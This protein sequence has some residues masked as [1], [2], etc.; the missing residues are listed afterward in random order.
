[1]ALKD[2]LPVSYLLFTYHGRIGRGTYW[3]ASLFIWTSFY[4]LFNLLGLISYSATWVIYPLLF[5]AIIATATKRLHDTNK[6]GFWLWLVLIPV[7]GPILLIYFLGFR[8]GKKAPN[9]FGDFPS[10]APDYFKNN[11]GIAIEHLKSN[12]R[13]INDVTQLNPV[14][15]SSIAVPTS[16]ETLQDIIKKSEKVSIGGGRFSMGG[17]TASPGTAHIDMRKLNKVLVFSKEEKTIKVEAGIRWCD[18]QKYID[19][20]DLSIKIMQTYAN[21]TVGGALSVNCHGRYIGEGA[22]ILSVKNIEV[23]MATGELEFCSPTENPDLFFACIGC[24]NAV[25]VIATVTFDLADNIPVKRVF[26]KLDRSEYKDFFDKKVSRNKD[27]IFHNGNIYPPHYKRVRAVSWVKTDEKP[28]EK[29]RLMPLAGAYPLERYFINAFSKNKFGKW[30]REHIIDPLV[31]RSKKIHW[32]NY[33]AGYD[34]LELEPE[35]RKD[36]TYVLQEYFVPVNNFDGFSTLMAEI[37]QRHNVN[38]INISI[39]HAE[40]DK[41]SLLAWSREEVFAFVVWHKQFTSDVEKG[42]VAVWTRE[43]IDAAIS[44]NGSYYLPY[45]AHATERQFHKAYP[46]AKKL[47][48]LKSE[49]DPAFKFRNVLWDTYYKT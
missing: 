15:V 44:Q 19:Q 1:M 30:R 40:K 32:R 29:T 47:F 23:I 13:I 5:W 33:E 41:G 34:V 2:K 16:I 38:V 46:D 31:Y 21:F 12:E 37:F 8:K 6:S 9:R 18:I 24:Y 3:L 14:L 42:K 28:T 10:A 11:D 26:K 36:S 17:Q 27:V 39:R 7:L 43:L 25:G 22:V 4:I 35:S 49:L 48:K 20:Y 45:Q